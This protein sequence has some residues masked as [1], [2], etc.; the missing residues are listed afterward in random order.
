[1]N[2]QENKLVIRLEYLKLIHKA[3][4]ADDA[5]TTTEK[6]QIEDMIKNTEDDI[7][8]CRMLLKNTQENSDD[9]RKLR[10]REEILNELLSHNN[11]NGN[12]DILSI[13]IDEQKELKSNCG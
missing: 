10:K 7:Y 6:V 2:D 8:E 9:E 11:A 5:F 3:I 12:E 1:M 4:C 13:F